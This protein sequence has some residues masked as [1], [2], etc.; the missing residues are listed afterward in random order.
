MMFSTELE[1]KKNDPKR[2]FLMEEVDYQR[3]V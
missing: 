1:R 3:N 2:G